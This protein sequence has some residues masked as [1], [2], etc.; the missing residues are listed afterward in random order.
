MTRTIEEQLASL[1]DAVEAELE[2]TNDMQVISLDDRRERRMPLVAAAAALILVIVGV[3]VVAQNVGTDRA[4]VSGQPEVEDFELADP[5]NIDLS[6]LTAQ[7][8]GRRIAEIGRQL[9]FDW[10]ALPNDWEVTMG[11][12]FVIS[13]VGTDG[14][15]YF[16]AAEIRLRGALT[17][18]ARIWGGLNG[19]PPPF[20]L[21]EFGTAVDVRGQ[22]GLLTSGQIE[23][24]EAGSLWVTLSGPPLAELD[25][26]YL[27][28]ANLLM[29]VEAAIPW[30]GEQSLGNRANPEE[31]PLLAGRLD[32]FGWE[33]YAEDRPGSA[34]TLV[35]D[36]FEVG[37][38]PFASPLDPNEVNIGIDSSV[39]GVV[40]LLDMPDTV[41]TVLLRTEAGDARLPAVDAAPGRTASAIPIEDVIDPVA[42]DLLDDSGDA[43]GTFPLDELT[44]F[45]SQS[46]GTGLILS[47]S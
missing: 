1:G 26:D 31:N 29:P 37:G 11:D 19:G 15:A 13:S 7:S 6:E 3:A 38:T 2:R 22:P 8:E 43:L 27:D 17:F 47:S 35:V 4:V 16:Q 14:P 9:T 45:T 33:V 28:V 23:W 20:A 36:G 44:P 18:D 25:A 5:L 21:G 41:S 42:L 34:L 24:I 40:V 46:I 30:T 10:D 12:A 32:E 39:G